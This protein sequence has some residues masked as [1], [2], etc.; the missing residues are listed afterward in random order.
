[1]VYFFK[2]SNSDIISG[3]KIDS[4]RIIERWGFGFVESS[5]KVFF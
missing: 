1:M 4:D 3:G 2:N 5:F